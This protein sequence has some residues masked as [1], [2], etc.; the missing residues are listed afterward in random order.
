MIYNQS[1]W[2][3]ED[4]HP[5][6]IIKSL[7]CDFC[8]I[9]AQA[10][11]PWLSRTRELKFFSKSV[12]QMW[13]GRRRPSCNQGYNNSQLRPWRVTHQRAWIVHYHLQCWQ[14][15]SC[16][17]PSA[18]QT[19]LQQVH[20]RSILSS[21]KAGCILESKRTEVL[22]KHSHHCQ[23]SLDQILYAVC[24][25]RMALRSSGQIIKLV[26]GR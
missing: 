6:C 10:S 22:Y 5:L 14:L 7:P 20:T 19:L 24:K 26:H 8:T 23:D 18:D 3:L 16:I 1:T 17:G 11:R 9:R 15:L 2:A 21:S 13:R 25:I 4:W 12:W